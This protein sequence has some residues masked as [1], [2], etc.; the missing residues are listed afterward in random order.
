MHAHVAVLMSV[1]TKSGFGRI[2]EMILGIYKPRHHTYLRGNCSGSKWR[3]NFEG[4]F[5]ASLY[6]VLQHTYLCATVNLKVSAPLTP[7]FLSP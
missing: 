6:T 2:A 3:I 1:G 7:D 4:F 5:P